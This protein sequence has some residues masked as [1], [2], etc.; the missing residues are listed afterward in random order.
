M[1]ATRRAWPWVLAVLILVPVAAGV[2]WWSGRAS[3]AADAPPTAAP[4]ADRTPGEPVTPLPPP[5][6]AVA[7]T[8]PLPALSVP[9]RTTLPELRRR[10]DAGEPAA[11]CRLGAE[12]AYCD[13]IRRRLDEAAA[14]NV[15]LPP[16]GRARDAEQDAAGRSARQAHAERSERLLQES[17]HCDGVPA[18]A[19][20]E[21]VRYWRI[22]ARGGS[23]P[24]I[25][26]YVQ[27]RAF[28]QENRLHDLEA[29][30]VYRSE[31]E[32]IA[33][34]G[35]AAGDIQTT[36][37]L[38]AAYADRPERRSLLSQA[39]TP[40][41]SMSLALFLQ[42]QS[43]LDQPAPGMPPQGRMFAP[44][45]AELERSLDPASLARA[46]QQAAAFRRAA[47]IPA[48][49]PLS[50]SPNRLPSGGPVSLLRDLCTP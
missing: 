22:A 11:A 13:D 39:V 1:D 8:G 12:M 10:A 48:S 41:A 40:D 6:S 32:A 47:P 14:P 28:Q 24:A 49:R 42:A 43:L 4:D 2:G 20:G 23:L 37:A 19:P 9:L 21:S 30:R 35:V 33:L 29:L 17:L 25:N 5:S 44:A 26:Y 50:R 18:F 36:L 16:P 7:T 27:G 38:A 46:R 45:I 3:V 15:Y 34:Q 31:A